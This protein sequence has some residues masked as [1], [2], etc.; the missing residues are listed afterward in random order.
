MS[1]KQMLLLTRGSVLLFSITATIMA[2]VRSDIYELVGESSVLSLVTLFAAMA[3][4]VYWKG[5]NSGGAML[6]M[7]A[8]FLAW[9]FFE[10]FYKTDIPSLVPATLISLISLVLG[11]LLLK[12]KNENRK[13]LVK[14]F[15]I[16]K[17]TVFTSYLQ[18]DIM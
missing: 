6:S 18:C 14:L 10:F 1:D 5:A 2:C 3:L 8:G 16:L 4:G 15:T 13:A 9:V 11:S 17:F 12:E 7:A